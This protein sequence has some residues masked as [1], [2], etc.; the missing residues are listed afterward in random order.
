MDI[1][2]VIQKEQEFAHYEFSIK[3]KS[4]IAEEDILKLGA[5]RLGTVIHEDKYFI[6]KGKKISEVTDLVRVRKEGGEILLFTYKRPILGGRIRGSLATTKSIQEKDVADIKKEY[7]EV[8][9]VNKRRTIFLLDPVVINLDKV[10]NL[11]NFLDF[12]VFKEEDCYQIDSL[13]K[14]LGL[15]PGDSIKLTYFQ[16]TVMDLDPLQRIFVKI[17]EKSGKFSYG[18]SSAV[19]TTLGVIVGLNSATAS[20]IAVIGGI[21]AVAIADSLSDSMGMYAAKTT[22]RGVSSAVA[23]RNALNVFL[24]KFIFTLTFIIPFII[25]PFSFAIYTC[26]AWGLILLTFVNFQIAF[27]QEKNI[28]KTIIKNILIAIVVIIISYLAGKGVDLLS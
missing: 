6:P 13:I 16:L 8:V 25:F 26:I 14:K 24:G 2:N 10:E 3:I 4:N 21:V 18:I 20:Q 12:S 5:Q 1:K 15:D 19:L 9:S 11:G 23:F 17:H 28:P 22:E 27:I 7:D